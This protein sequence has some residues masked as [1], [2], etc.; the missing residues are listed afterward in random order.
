MPPPIYMRIATLL[1]ADLIEEMT[2]LPEHPAY[3]HPFD[4]EWIRLSEIAPDRT[5]RI[6][7]G[8][9]L[10]LDTAAEGVDTIHAGRILV[11]TPDPGNLTFRAE[12]LYLMGG[13][14][15]Q[16]QPASTWSRGIVCAET[17]KPLPEGMHWVWPA[18]RKDQPSV[19]KICYEDAGFSIWHMIALELYAPE[20]I[21]AFLKVAGEQPEETVQHDLW[22]FTTDSP[23]IEPYVEAYLWENELWSLPWTVVKR[24]LAYKNPIELCM[25]AGRPFLEY[26][27]GFIDEAQLSKPV[28][29][30]RS[31]SQ[32]MLS[33]SRSIGIRDS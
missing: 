3:V 27:M 6:E 1:W 16:I 25:L 31:G 13:D 10:W 17:G 20:K 24:L 8:K 33:K 29:D 18:E 9:G 2:D 21:P 28:K 22:E 11:D 19:G 5:L 23:S 14:P 32:W 26:A 15:D 30:L 12:T 4:K 7:E